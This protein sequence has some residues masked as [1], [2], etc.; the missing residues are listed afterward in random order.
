MLAF[1]VGFAVLAGASVGQ[2][3]GK[4]DDPAPKAEKGDK[5]DKGDVKGNLPQYWKQLGLTDEQKTKVQKLNGKYGA[6]IDKLK[7]Q[8]KEVTE[9]RDKERL[10]VLT[11][12]QKK[13]LEA[14]IKEKAG[15]DKEKA[16]K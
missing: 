14:I 7:Q 4:K 6:E 10:E 13:R 2:E 11:P 9:K 3:K 1:L 15:T 5:A 8:I 16:G 12:E